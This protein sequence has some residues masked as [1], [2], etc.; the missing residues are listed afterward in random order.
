[1]NRI[2]KTVWNAA[3]T[4]LVVVNEKAGIGRSRHASG[5]GGGLRL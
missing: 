5:G 3:R 1:M 2:F 4:A